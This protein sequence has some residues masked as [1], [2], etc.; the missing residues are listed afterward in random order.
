MINTEHSKY[1]HHA[2]FNDN[3]YQ[4]HYY[5]GNA[6]HDCQGVEEVT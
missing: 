1:C 6:L 5:Y 2:R 3:R 4:Y